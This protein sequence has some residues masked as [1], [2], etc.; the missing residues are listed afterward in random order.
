MVWARLSGFL[1]IRRRVH[2]GAYTDHRVDPYRTWLLDH[3]NAATHIP[4]P[5]QALPLGGDPLPIDVSANSDNE[6]RFCLSP[7]HHHASIVGVFPPV[8]PTP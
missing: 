1:V 2:I 4:L 6:L 7:G 5:H 8:F 3:V